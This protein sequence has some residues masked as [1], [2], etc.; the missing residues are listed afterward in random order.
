MRVDMGGKLTWHIAAN[1][2]N[3]KV[4]RLYVRICST[5]VMLHVP[6]I[7]LMKC[8]AWGKHLLFQI[9]WDMRCGLFLWRTYETMLLF[10]FFFSEVNGS[11]LPYV[12]SRLLDFWPW[13]RSPDWV[14]NVEACQ[15]I[16]RPESGWLGSA[17][18][19]VCSSS[20]TTR[21][22]TVPEPCM[23]RSAKVLRLNVLVIRFPQKE[24]DCRV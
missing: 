8:E 23:N 11:L 16:S 2:I 5:Y 18:G 7:K 19:A 6:A 21:L 15:G 20:H 1:T 9:N 22:K 13:V 12:R 14:V 17:T 10:F 3:K 4:C 24:E